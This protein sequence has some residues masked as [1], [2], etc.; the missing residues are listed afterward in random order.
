MRSVVME[1]MLHMVNAANLLNAIGGSPDF[2][3][4]DFIPKYPLMLPVLNITADIVWFTQTSVS[5][6]EILE[7]T[8]PGGYNS[9]ISALYMHILS[10]LQELCKLYGEDK[11]F[12][13]NHSYQVPAQISSGEKAIGIYSLADAAQGLVGV[14]EQG[15]GCPIPGQPYPEYSNISAGPNGGEFS[16]AARYVSIALHLP[17][18]AFRLHSICHHTQD[19]CTP[20][21]ITRTRAR[22]LRCTAA[23][24]S[25]IAYACLTSG[26]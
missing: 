8:P 19:D 2:D 15:G 21:A 18:H 1:E 16:H 14:A 11:I 20:S 9:S 26:R 7:S 5:H 25:T 13:G 24:H 3:I 17:P 22:L 12:T 10:L 4:P 23:V 6:Y